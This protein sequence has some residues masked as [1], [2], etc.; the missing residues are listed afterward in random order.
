MPQS[1]YVL[2]EPLSQATNPKETHGGAGV[3]SYFRRHV[4]AVTRHH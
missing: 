1:A 2:P 3:S 4:V